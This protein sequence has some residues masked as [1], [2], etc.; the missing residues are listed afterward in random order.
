MAG[1]INS[2]KTD[3]FRC[4]IKPKYTYTKIKIY[5]LQSYAQSVRALPCKVPN[6]ES[7]PNANNIE[8]NSTAHKLGNGNW[9]TASVKSMKAK[10]GPLAA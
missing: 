4:L 7:S 10:P 9:L 3:E 1:I 2:I 8:K 5:I 6:C